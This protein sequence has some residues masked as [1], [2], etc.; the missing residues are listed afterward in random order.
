[1][2]GDFEKMEDIFSCMIFFNRKG[3]NACH[4]EREKMHAIK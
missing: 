4:I 3:E 1:L 2:N